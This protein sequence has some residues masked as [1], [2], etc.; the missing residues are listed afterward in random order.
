MSERQFEGAEMDGRRVP[1]R[2]VADELITTWVDARKYSSPAFAAIQ[3]HKTQW[4]TRHM[5]WNQEM[6]E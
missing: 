5:E 4:D 6:F 3:C 1:F 2:L